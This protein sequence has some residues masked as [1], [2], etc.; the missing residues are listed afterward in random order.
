MQMFLMMEVDMSVDE[1]GDQH[2][3][4][5]IDYL[6]CSF[7]IVAKDISVYDHQCTVGEASP[8]EYTDIL[9]QAFPSGFRGFCRR[10]LKLFR[11]TWGNVLLPTV[12]LNVIHK[13][14][15]T[16]GLDYVD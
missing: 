4:L 1:T 7:W 11:S 6:V 5:S 9:E 13:H 8:V 10:H 2:R 3:A 16:L 15:V 12:I 14:Y